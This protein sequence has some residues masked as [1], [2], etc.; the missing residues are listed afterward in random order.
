MRQRGEGAR[1]YLWTMKFSARS[2]VGVNEC[3]TIGITLILL[4]LNSN[5][6]TPPTPHCSSQ[7][8]ISGM[9]SLSTQVLHSKIVTLFLFSFSLPAVLFA[10]SGNST[11]HPSGP[12]SYSL[13]WLLVCFLHSL[14]TM[15]KCLV[16]CLPI[17]VCVPTDT[18]RSLRAGPMFI[19]FIYLYSII[20]T[21][22]SISRK[23]NKH[24]T[25]E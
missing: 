8:P 21:V 10:K 1:G 19:L 15:L 25:N 22:P 11:N 4:I 14:S 17:N 6:F 2:V 7:S 3:L 9:A 18:L 5:H 13:P 20:S 12:L 23:L 16:V 24:S